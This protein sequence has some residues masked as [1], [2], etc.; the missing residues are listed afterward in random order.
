MN[1]RINFSSGVPIY[2]QLMEQIKHAVETG[3]IRAGEQLPTIRAVAEELTMNPNTVAR[4][5]RELE[6]EGVVEVRHGSGVF[7]AGPRNSSAKSNEI[8]KTGEV[9]RTAMEKGMALGL[10]EAE[11]RRVFEDELSHLQ[12]KASGRRRRT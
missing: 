5:Y 6:G 4:T 2:L 12:E 7:V 3:A 1:L 10:K 11:L 8:R 9:L